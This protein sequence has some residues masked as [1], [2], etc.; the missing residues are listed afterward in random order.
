MELI[1]LG[2]NHSGA[3]T[4]D[5]S[6]YMW[7]RNNRGQLR[8]GTTLNSI[9]PKKIE[10]PIS[11]SVAD[12]YVSFQQ[13]T[14]ELS[15]KNASSN[16]ILTNLVPNQ[17]YNFYIMKSNTEDNALGANNLLYIRQ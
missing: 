17:T 7:G 3:I 8:D 15:Y 12:V 13:E 2:D 11:T 6:L 16:E 5:G 1:S 9:I 14:Y 4:K 10:L